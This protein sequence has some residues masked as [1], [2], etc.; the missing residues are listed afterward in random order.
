MM[1]FSNPA[2]HEVT[3]IEAQTMR[4]AGSSGPF[5]A[6]ELTFEG[7][8]DGAAH[9]TIY[10]PGDSHVYAARIAQAINQIN[11]SIDDAAR[12]QHEEDVSDFVPF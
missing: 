2:I 10:L 3:R 1:K 9:M 7:T 11:A 12:A 8:R 6:L 5:T 4:V